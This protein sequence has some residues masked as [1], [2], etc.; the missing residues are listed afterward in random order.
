MTM[1]LHNAQEQMEALA[2]RSI[3]ARHYGRPDQPYADAEEQYAGEL[4]ALAARELV[5][6]VDA[7]PEDARP[8]GW[9]L[10]EVSR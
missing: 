10:V 3:T 4:L 7:L 2:L 8:V 9:D 1:A 5:R 6:A